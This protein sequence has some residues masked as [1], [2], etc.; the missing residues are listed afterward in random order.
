MGPKK[1]VILAWWRRQQKRVT[2]IPFAMFTV[3]HLTPP[4]GPTFTPCPNRLSK[5][6]GGALDRWIFLHGE[7]LWRPHR[8]TSTT[9]VTHNLHAANSFPVHTKH[10]LYRKQPW[11]DGRRKPV[12]R[13][14][15]RPSVPT[16]T[17]QRDHPMDHQR[18][19]LRNNPSIR[20]ACLIYPASL[21]DIVIF[22]LPS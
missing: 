21:I 20:Y 15:V 18:H 10:N 2:Y 8:C 11:L 19:N 6:A 13:Q 22:S 16:T 1:W 7:H 4:P 5:S 12:S 3:F 14:S 9:A 17:L